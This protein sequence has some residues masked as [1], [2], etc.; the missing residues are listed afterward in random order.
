MKDH[1]V[2]CAYKVLLTVFGTLGGVLVFIVAIRLRKTTTFV[3]V[4]FL[5]VTDPLTL[6]CWNLCNFIRIYFNY[7]VTEESIYGCKIVTY[8]AFVSM[9]SSAWLLVSLSLRKFSSFTTELLMGFFYCQGDA[10]GWPLLECLA[11][12]LE[13]D[14][15][16]AQ[17]STDS[18]LGLGCVLYNLA[19]NCLVHLRL[20]RIWRQWD[21]QRLLQ[22]PQDAFYQPHEHVVFGKNFNQRCSNKTT[23]DS[24]ICSWILKAPRN[25]VRIYTIR[26]DNGDQCCLDHLLENAQQDKKLND[27]A[28]V[29]KKS[30][31]NT[32]VILFT[33]I[34][35]LMTLPGSIVSL[36][37][38]TWLSIEY[39]PAVIFTFDAVSSTYHALSF[40]ILII[41]NTRFKKELVKI[42]RI[43]GTCFFKRTFRESTMSF[44]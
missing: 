39:G 29:S 13:D 18:L 2:I 32:T 36:F 7:L 23:L 41:S 5:A 24:D 15:L 42:I 25:L 3:F 28:K 12:V 1:D 6:Y 14:L 16:Q 10:V 9:Q 27:P 20:S 37:I 44:K 30:S 22:Q 21:L 11:Q 34:F 4:T 43:S 40:L 26:T 8:L 33:L 19:L 17:T 38:N 35:V 31:M